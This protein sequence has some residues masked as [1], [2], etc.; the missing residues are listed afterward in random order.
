MRI[1]KLTQVN[2]TI[3]PTSSDYK[4]LIQVMGF[5]LIVK[6]EEEEEGAQYIAAGGVRRCWPSGVGAFVAKGRH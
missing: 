4:T 6:E 2:I 5:T 1:L 3:E